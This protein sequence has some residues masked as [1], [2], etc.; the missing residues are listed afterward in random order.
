MIINTNYRMGAF[1]DLCR[2]P[3]GC[4][5]CCGNWQTSCPQPCP[6]FCNSPCQNPCLSPCNNSCDCIDLHFSKNALFFM[7]GYLISKSIK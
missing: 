6:P 2:C 7:A 3:C 4:N 5:P 1:V